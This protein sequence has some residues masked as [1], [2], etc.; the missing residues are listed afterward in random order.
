MKLSSVGHSLSHAQ[1]R[2]GSDMLHSLGR[3]HSDPSL[4]ATGRA[5]HPFQMLSGS[6]MTLSL[7]VWCLLLKAGLE[8]C[9]KEHAGEVGIR[10]ARQMEKGW[11][12]RIHRYKRK[13]RIPCVLIRHLG[14]ILN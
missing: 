8:C 10:E 12:E 9:T 5:T 3:F 1:Q 6:S 2:E 7:R 14:R 13:N 11:R 4:Q